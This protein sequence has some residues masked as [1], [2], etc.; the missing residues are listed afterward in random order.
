M[1]I[2]GIT[3]FSS[4]K[5]GLETWFLFLREEYRMR[6]PGHKVKISTTP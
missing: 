5:H 1:N 4:P 6:V 2:T 3:P